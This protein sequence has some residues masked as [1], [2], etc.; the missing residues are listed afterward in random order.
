MIR[1]PS[2]KSYH[3]G[4][5][6]SAA[7]AVEL[8]ES[9]DGSAGLSVVEALAFLRNRLRV[10]VAE[11]DGYCRPCSFRRLMG[12]VLG[13]PTPVLRI[14]R[15]P[16]EEIERRFLDGFETAELGRPA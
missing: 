14:V 3:D 4:P 6:D 2:C 13:R 5:R 16:D 7:L 10:V 11:L 8:R 15:D 9:V 1:C 12:G